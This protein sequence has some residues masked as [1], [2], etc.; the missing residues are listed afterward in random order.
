MIMIKFDKFTNQVADAPRVTQRSLD[1]SISVSSCNLRRNCWDL[2]I[3]HKAR[4]VLDIRKSGAI[5]NFILP[6]VF[7]LKSG[8]EYV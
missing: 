3:L 2:T 7:K 8:G 4:S 5:D 1:K 6:S